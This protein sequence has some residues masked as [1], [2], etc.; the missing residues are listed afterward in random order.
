[1]C[2][3]TRTSLKAKILDELTEITSSGVHQ[4][5]V[6]I[7]HRKLKTILVCA[8]YRPPDCPINC[9]VQEFFN[10]Y[11]LARTHGKEQFIIGDFNC[12]MSKHNHDSKELKDLGTCLNLT[13]LI[14]SPTRVTTHSSTLKVELWK[15]A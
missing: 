3:Y 15:M 1:M 8:I 10:K 5:W 9:L 12:D 4:L 2:I 6:Q 11:I 7:Q 13:L 14:S